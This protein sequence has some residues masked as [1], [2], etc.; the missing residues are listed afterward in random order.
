MKLKSFCT[1]KKGSLNRRGYPQNGRKLFFSYISD[2]GKYRE[3]KK[4]NH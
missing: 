2:K 3:F 1:T 4:I